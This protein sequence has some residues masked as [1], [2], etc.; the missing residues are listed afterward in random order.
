MA[1]GS[2]QREKENSMIKELRAIRGKGGLNTPQAVAGAAAGG[3]VG[4]LIGGGSGG[5]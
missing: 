3:A 1:A 4:G 5:R 2:S